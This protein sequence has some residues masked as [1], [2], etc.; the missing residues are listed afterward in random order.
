MLGTVVQ[1]E[2]MSRHGVYLDEDE[3]KTNKEPI[4]HVEDTVIQIRIGNKRITMRPSHEDKPAV[5]IPVGMS[6]KRNTCSIPRDWATGV[7][8]DALIEA[9]SGDPSVAF[10]FAERV[11]QAI[12][13]AMVTDEDTGK[14]SVKQADL[15]SHKHAVEV[16]EIV[17]SLKRHFH[18]KSAG[19]PKLNMDFHVEEIGGEWRPQENA[20]E[21]H[22]MIQEMLDNTRKE[23]VLNTL[24][25]NPN[26]TAT[27]D[28]TPDIPV[29]QEVVIPAVVEASH[30]EAP[31]P[32]TLE[33][34]PTPIVAVADTVESDNDQIDI[35]VDEHIDA[36]EDGVIGDV[37]EEEVEV[38]LGVTGY[39]EH[40][41]NL[42]IEA[43]NNADED[44]DSPDGQVGPTWG[45]I[46]KALSD[47]ILEDKLDLARKCLDKLVKHGLVAKEGV[48][49]STRYLLTGSGLEM[50]VGMP[51]PDVISQE[52]EDT[53]FKPS[54]DSVV[55]ETYEPAPAHWSTGEESHINNEAGGMSMWTN[56][57]EEVKAIKNE[58]DEIIS[59]AEPWVPHDEGIEII[60]DPVIDEPVEVLPTFPTIGTCANSGRP[61]VFVVEDLPVGPRG[62]ATEKD[63]CEYAGLEYKHEGYY[64][65]SLRNQPMG[66]YDPPVEQ[67]DEDTSV[68]ITGPAS[69]DIGTD[70][71]PAMDYLGLGG[72]Y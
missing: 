30:P 40:M 59:D 51:L 65:E 8:I 28:N 14:Q 22:A 39:A 2:W 31:V 3:R 32:V 6:D 70:D 20:V 10:A 69:I 21:T 50:L 26:V 46:K 57:P 36:I 12:D 58:F 15:P 45:R 47:T 43:I 35:I 37:L 23:A 63:Y 29:A 11:N 54:G 41:E 25:P 48:R 52:L 24:V 62:F 7:W 49:R 16:A 5:V 4:A 68:P 60:E 19:S 1:E 42:I 53:P 27:Q 34:E 71:D 72:G 18:G 33:E 56:D 66:H 17:E 64:I 55:A 67:E 9:F 38:S 13:M 44:N 61:A